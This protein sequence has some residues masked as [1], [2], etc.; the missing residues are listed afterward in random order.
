M[1][2]R[3]GLYLVRETDAGFGKLEVPGDFL[4]GRG[5]A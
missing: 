3:I 1:A 2:P 4:Q 5:T